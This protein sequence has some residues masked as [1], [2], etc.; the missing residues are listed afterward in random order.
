[1]AMMQW[2]R[3]MAPYL[4]GAVLVAFLVSLAY[5]GGR[6]ITED[7]GGHEAVVTVNGEGVSAI[8]MEFPEYTQTTDTSKLP[9]AAYS[10][11]AGAKSVPSANAA[12]QAGAVDPPPA[13]AGATGTR[14]GLQSVE[15]FRVRSVKSVAG[16]CPQK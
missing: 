2:M 4:L 6:G 5:F 8:A 15:E 1:M 14:R 12:A 13:A 3:G 9:I 7:R 16:A 11:D 10:S